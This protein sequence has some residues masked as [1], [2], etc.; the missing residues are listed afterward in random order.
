MFRTSK[1]SSSGRIV[2]AVLWYFF[3]SGRCQENVF[4][5]HPN[6]THPDV[7]QT[8]RNT[9]KLHVHVFLIMNTWMFETCRRHYN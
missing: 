5:S 9:I 4:D 8:E 2:H 1:C 7:D 3:Q 6:Q